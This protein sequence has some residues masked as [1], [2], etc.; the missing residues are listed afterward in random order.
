[1]RNTHNHRIENA[2]VQHFG[3][4]KQ[5]TRQT[6]RHQRAQCKA[7]S[8]HSRNHCITIGIK[9]RTDTVKNA[10]HWRARHEQVASEKFLDFKNWQHSIAVKQVERGRILNK[11]KIANPFLSMFFFNSFFLCSSK[12]LYCMEI[13]NRSKLTAVNCIVD[14]SIFFQSEQCICTFAKLCEGGKKNSRDVSR[15]KARG[16]LGHKIRDKQCSVFRTTSYA[17]QLTTE[18]PLFGNLSWRGWFE[19]RNIPSTRDALLFATTQPIV[20]LFQLATAI[21]TSFRISIFI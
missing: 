11:R 12:S 7:N 2:T 17:R 18:T 8:E 14:L 15:V 16:K 1:M 21:T 20:F 10:K 4:N 3:W 6:Y 19:M 13:N 9:F 5:S